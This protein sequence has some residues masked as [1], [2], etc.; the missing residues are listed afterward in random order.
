MSRSQGLEFL[1]NHRVLNWSVVVEHFRLFAGYPQFL[2][3]FRAFV[4]TIHPNFLLSNNPRNPV[5]G[6]QTVFFSPRSREIASQTHTSWEENAVCMD[7]GLKA[8]TNALK[9]DKKKSTQTKTKQ[10]QTKTRPICVT[11]WFKLL[12]KLSACKTPAILPAPLGLQVFLHQT[13]L[14]PAFHNCVLQAQTQQRA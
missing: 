10:K 8:L 12:L 11:K 9:K 5:F 3:S 1:R 2:F 4:C 7:A 14:K 6:A 13:A